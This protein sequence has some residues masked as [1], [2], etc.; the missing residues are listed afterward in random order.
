ML[1]K[2]KCV[3]V[4]KSFRAKYALESSDENTIATIHLMNT[5]GI[6]IHAAL[7]QSSRSG[8]DHGIDAWFYDEHDRN[9]FIYQSKMN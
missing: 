3:P 4:I 2:D 5:H 8:N 9:L 7:D 6:D 1:T